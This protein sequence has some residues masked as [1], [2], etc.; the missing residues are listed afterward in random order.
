MDAAASPNASEPK[1]VVLPVVRPLRWQHA[2]V[3]RVIHTAP[4]GSMNRPF[5]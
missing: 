5:E 3:E 1:K 2:Y 4:A